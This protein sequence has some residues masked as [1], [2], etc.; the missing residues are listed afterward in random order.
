LEAFGKFRRVGVGYS[1]SPPIQN[2]E[3]FVHS[4]KV[5]SKADIALRKLLS[6]TQSFKGAPARI[7]LENIIAQQCKCSRV[8]AGR[9][10]G[11]IGSIIPQ[12]PTLA[13]WSIEGFRAASKGVFQPNSFNGLS[14]IPSP[15]M[16]RAFNQTT[17]LTL[18]QF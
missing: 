7:N 10:P 15:I 12:T 3:V 8:A 18:N 2:G 1:A 13:K 17:P 16:R 14:A 4:C 9:I 6:P 5:A 11:A